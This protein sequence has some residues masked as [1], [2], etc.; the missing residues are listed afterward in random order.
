MSQTNA[1]DMALGTGPVVQAV[2]LLLIFYSVVSWAVIFAKWKSYQKAAKQSEHFLD[3]FANMKSL[4]DIFAETKNYGAS[5]VSNVFRAGYI[6]LQKLMGKSQDKQNASAVLS[7]GLENIQR[8]LRKA[9]LAE[10]L[11]H[12][13]LLPWLATIASTAPYIGLFGTVWGIMSA[14]QGLAQGG[15]ATIQR[16]APGISEALI[17]TAVGLAAAIPAVMAYNTFSNRLKRFRVDMD[18][19]STDF[20]NILKRH[21]LG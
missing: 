17:A 6:E 2:L 11:R 15:P 8:A 5:H 1:V 20:T 12:E 9:S 4:E 19:F 13:R 3:V 10:S 18:G 21:Y 7:L 14:F 16:V